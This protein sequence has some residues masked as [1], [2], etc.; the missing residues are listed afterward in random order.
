MTIAVLNRA[1][2]LLR[3]DLPQAVFPWWSFTKPVLAALVLRAA[4]R[5][6][7]D[8]DA[9]LSNRPYSLRQL[10]QHRAGVPEYGGLPRYKAA[11]AKVEPAWPAERLLQEVQADHL[12]FPPGQ[13]W[14]YSNTGYL[15]LRQELEA[16]HQQDLAAIMREEILE[17]LGLAARLAQVPADFTTLHYPAQGYH[18]GWVYHGCLIGTAQDAARLLW[19]L[20][21]GD[22]LS[23]GARQQML[24]RDMKGS[25]IPGRVW[26]EI[27]YGLGM[28]IGAV[29]QV[30]QMIG[31]TG[32]GPFSA[33]LVAAFPEMPNQPIVAAFCSG[34]DES[35]AE[36]AA[37]KAAVAKEQAGKPL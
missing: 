26:S 20:L 11:V 23:P 32:S 33:N 12:D 19:A 25:A 1:G 10:L 36:F 37:V 16:L 28:M 21:H 14:N 30:G 9:E 18:P 15:I 24:L 35:V 29:P 27:G 5:G 22:L 31:H 13:G 6:D 7:C 2:D 17:P 3:D 8:L 4:D 34:A